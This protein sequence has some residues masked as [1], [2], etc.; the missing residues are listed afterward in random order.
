MTI[1]PHA[2]C[3]PRAPRAPAGITRPLVQGERH[4]ALHRPPA[5]TVR[6]PVQVT[7]KFSPS[8]RLIAL[9]STAHCARPVLSLTVSLLR[10]KQ[11][12]A[13]FFHNCTP[14]LPRR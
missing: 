3:S 11:H 12:T 9:T 1:L 8:R 10:R 7:P 13:F 6:F 4:P 5:Y 14:P 2:N